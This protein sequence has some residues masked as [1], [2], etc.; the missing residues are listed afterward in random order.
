M[1][2]PTVK[3]ILIP[4]IALFIILT[5]ALCLAACREKGDDELPSVPNGNDTTEG[6]AEDA[7]IIDIG[8]LSDNG[9]VIETGEMLK[10]VFVAEYRGNYIF[11]MDSSVNLELRSGD[12]P[13]ETVGGAFSRE[14]SS[15]AKFEFEARN[16]GS[17]NVTGNI[18][19]DVAGVSDD[20]ITV[21]AT[22]NESFI[23]KFSPAESVMY[24]LTALQA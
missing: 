18:S 5:S 14:L 17:E 3:K 23:M 21:E 1:K 20:K 7:E 9:Y 13:V 8:L 2:R 15:G 16:A 4:I 24:D 19:V 12:T 6:G 11:G 10:F 22:A